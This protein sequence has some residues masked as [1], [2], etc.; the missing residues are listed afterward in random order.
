MA[1]R[2]LIA[3][4]LGSV[5]LAQAPLRTTVR[6][7]IA[8][9]TVVDSHGK[10]I[11]GL[12]EPDFVL[13]DNGEQ[14]PVHVDFA[15]FPI[16]LVVAVQRS[17]FSAAVLNKAHKIGSLLEPMVTGERGEVAVIAYDGEIEVQQEFTTDFEKVDSAL[18]RIQP[19]D[20]SA[21]TVDAVAE[22]VR[23]LASRPPERRRVLLLI[24]E[25]KDRNS[26]TKLDAAV[27]LAQQ[28]NVTIYPLTYSPYTTA[29]TAKAGTTPPPDHTTTNLLVLLPEIARLAQTNAAAAFAR[30]TGG[31]RLSFTRQKSLEL[32]VARIGE[33]L[34]S[35]YLLSFAAPPDSSGTFHAITVAVPGQPGA[36]VRTR[37]GYWMAEPQP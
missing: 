2:T 30:Y 28:E 31:E 34:H 18:K 25:A 8:P 36:K 10:Y 22:S 29:F 6:L 20:Y 15:S 33:E 26:R 35:Q 19:G 3:L 11:D 17:F 4:A 37:P 21:R 5:A 9:T 32:A 7:V 13:R 14:R 1:N 16:S 27:T 12:S 24:S 23:L